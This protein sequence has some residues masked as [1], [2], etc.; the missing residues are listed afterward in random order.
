MK[1]NIF[2]T[3]NKREAIIIGIMLVI[4]LFFG[5]VFFGGSEESHSEH[6]HE[7]NANAEETIYT[8]SMHPQ[9]KQN[10]PGLCP[11]CAMDLVPITT[12]H[13]EGD[14][15][16]PNEIQ[17]TESAM[18]LADVQTAIVKYGIPEK[19]VHL[20][21]KV[22]ADERNIA[23][24]TARFGGRIEKL[25]VNYT[26]QNVKKGQKLG[27][28]YSPDLI[29]AQRELLEAIKYKESNPSFYKASRSKLKLWDLTNDQIDDIEANGEPKLYFDIL[30]PISG[31]V[32]KRHVATGSY[33]KEGSALFELIDL[34]RVWVM[35]DAY[36]SDLPWIKTGD[37]INFTLQSMP[38][39]SYAGKVSYIDP[40][41]NAYTR[42][43]QVRVEIINKDKAFK[44]E[45]FANGILESNIAK[46]SNELLI[47][48]SATL[49]TGKRAVVY[50]KVPNHKTPSFLYRE[51]ILG[52]E[53]GNFYVVA[54]GL[55]EGEIIATNGVFKID[56]SAQLAGKPSM[57]NPEGGKIST[58]H[59]HGG[60]QMSDEE[61]KAMDPSDKKAEALNF[62]DV[63]ETFKRQLGELVNDYLKM[64]DAFVASDEK[65]VEA[66]TKT[67]LSSFNKIDMTLLKGNTHV[68]WMN[69]LKSIKENLNGIITMKGIEMKRSHFSIVSNKL[70]EAIDMFGIASDQPVYLE[71]CPMAFDNKG[72][73]WIS[74][75]KEIRNSYFG[76]KMLTCGEVKKEFNN[77]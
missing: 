69:L 36:E 12:L 6:N 43:A 60:T 52:P 33:V 32:T 22:K 74:A 70:I 72:A 47:P 54:E 20:L 35:F 24:L 51:I 48:K 45:M 49:W 30:S 56:A 11:I 23:E 34:S 3:L 61:M 57:M 13:V 71:F 73:F 44:L 59:N 53:A 76:D 58:G 29:T 63:S 42:I 19:S 55:S 39:K 8:C 40:F 18:K 67:V 27:I 41:I 14:D 1:T 10:E 38:G 4:G 15:I 7:I 75:H 9:I 65:Q 28:I 2:K 26:G 68:E 16:D 50:V 66:E 46:N 31:T 25:F 21:G 37:K 77:Q 62:T 64:K 17:M 5:A